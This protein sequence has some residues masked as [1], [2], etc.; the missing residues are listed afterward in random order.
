MTYVNKTKKK[1]KGKE[2]FI[3][4]R[5]GIKFSSAWQTW[6]FRHSLRPATTV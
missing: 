3:L 2:K 6:I 1:K 5:S 4:T